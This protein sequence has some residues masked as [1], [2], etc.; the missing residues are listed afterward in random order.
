LV[1]L[2]HLNSGGDALMNRD[3]VADEP[4][5]AGTNPRA[6]VYVRVGA[7][8]P[9]PKAEAALLAQREACRE[10]CEHGFEVVEAGE[11]R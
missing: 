3:F 5:E 2:T 8:A 11:L 4:A 6:V 1:L 10:W 9:M 7:N